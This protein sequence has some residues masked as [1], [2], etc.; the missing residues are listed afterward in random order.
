MRQLAIILLVLPVTLNSQTSD[1]R[2]SRARPVR[3]DTFG[4]E[5]WRSAAALRNFVP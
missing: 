5:P 4:T 3:F 2:G 1:R